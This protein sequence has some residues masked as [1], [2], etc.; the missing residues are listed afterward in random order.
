MQNIFCCFITLLLGSTAAAQSPSPEVLLNKSIA[1][2]DPAGTWSNEAHHIQLKETRQNGSDRKTM[3]LIDLAQEHF[4]MTRE[5]ASNTVVQEIHQTTVRH[6]VDGRPASDS[7]LIK[8][9]R[10]Q[11]ERAMMMKDYYTYLY[12]L[13]MKLLDPGTLL[14][15]RVEDGSFNDRAAW[16]LRVTYAKDVGDDIWYFYFDK[17][18]YRLMG[19]RFYHDE[20]ANDGEYILLS[21]EAKVGRMRLPAERSWYMHKDNKYLGA[22]LI[23]QE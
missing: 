3:L 6:L 12:G 4:K 19:Y 13:P 11:D 16:S 23:I 14:A 17:E 20:E 10:L 18:T 21:G 8:K 15:D 22:D 2:H 5:V 7:A 1:Y 9:H